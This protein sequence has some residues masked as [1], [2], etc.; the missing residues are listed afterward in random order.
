MQNK[1]KMNK[2]NSILSVVLLAILAILAIGSAP[3]LYT[4]GKDF[5]RTVFGT[6]SNS[7]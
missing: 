7:K 6:S 2:S 4:I 5:G 3:T 1:P